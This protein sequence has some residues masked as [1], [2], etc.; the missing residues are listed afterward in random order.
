MSSDYD[1]FNQ[2]PI[3]SGLLRDKG[4]PYPRTCVIHGLHC[5]EMNKQFPLESQVVSL[6]TNYQ[7]DFIKLT[8]TEPRPGTIYTRRDSILWFVDEEIPGGHQITIMIQYQG[9]I[10]MVTSTETEYLKLLTELLT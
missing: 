9:N 8:F 1:S 6:K 7:D 10:K 3:C 2:R 4:L 5:A